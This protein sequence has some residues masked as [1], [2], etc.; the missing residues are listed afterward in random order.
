[1]EMTCMLKKN[2]NNPVESLHHA[3]HTEAGEGKRIKI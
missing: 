2:N 3:V 1:M